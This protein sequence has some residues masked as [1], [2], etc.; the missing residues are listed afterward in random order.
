MKSAAIEISLFSRIFLMWQ[1]IDLCIKMFLTIHIFTRAIIY[2]MRSSYFFKVKNRKS[3]SP[4]QVLYIFPI[5]LEIEATFQK[6]YKISEMC[7]VS[8]RKSIYDA[9]KHLSW[10]CVKYAR[11][12]VISDAHFPVQGQNEI[13]CC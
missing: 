6:R 8:M 9:T 11:I 12:R 13:F 10:H 4:S 2:I 1:M 5:L 7:N 3:E